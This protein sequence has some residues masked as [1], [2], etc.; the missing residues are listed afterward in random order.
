M[1][2]KLKSKPF[3]VSLATA[4]TIAINQE[5]IQAFVKENQKRVK[6]LAAFNEKSIS[7]HVALKRNK[8]G[9]TVCISAKRNK[10][11]LVLK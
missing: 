1:R 3:S 9:Y 6:V 10:K 4:S 7:Y 8:T 2:E 11:N 5:N